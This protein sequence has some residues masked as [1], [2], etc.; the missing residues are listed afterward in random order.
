M[1]QFD[2]SAVFSSGVLHP[3]P[4]RVV[5]NQKVPFTLVC[6]A[7]LAFAC[8]PSTRSDSA[9]TRSASSSAPSARLASDAALQPSFD[10]TVAGGVRFDFRVTNASE[11][12]LEVVFPDGR[13]HDVIVLDSLGREVW[14]W[15]DGRLF[16]QSVQNRVLRSSD[17]IRFDESWR[18]PAP[19]VY[20]AVATLAS[21]N[22]PVEQR[23][24]FVVR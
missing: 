18:A 21:V 4:V 19:G 24:E 16:T 7:V 17:S 10:V 11:K 9:T 12:K 15:S 13:T 2:D 3:P 23:R 5:M 14:R 1:S 20:T 8:G 22:F 6:V